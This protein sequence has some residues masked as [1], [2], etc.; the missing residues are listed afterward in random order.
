MRQGPVYRALP[1]LAVRGGTSRFV[2][3]GDLQHVFLDV[4]DLEGAVG[5]AMVMT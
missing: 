5:D 3:S 4:V 2:R 1:V